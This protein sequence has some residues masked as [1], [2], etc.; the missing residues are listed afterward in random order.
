MWLLT[1]LN[2]NIRKKASRIE[3][4]SENLQYGF[5]DFDERIEFKKQ[6]TKIFQIR[7]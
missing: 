7:L 3:L 5:L 2:K 6:P 1:I 4:R